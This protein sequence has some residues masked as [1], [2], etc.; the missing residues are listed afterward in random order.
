M[1]WVAGGGFALFLA[2]LI[3]VLV[4]EKRPVGPDLAITSTVNQWALDGGTFRVWQAITHFGESR[5]LTPLSI[6]LILIA[7]VTKRWRVAVFVAIASLYSM[8]SW[9][10]KV[11]VERPRPPIQHDYSLQQL[12]SFPSGHAG[13]AMAFASIAFC[14]VVMSLH[15]TAR[16]IAGVV[17]FAIAVLAGISRLALGVHYPTDVL[18]GFGLALA[19]VFSVALVVGAVA[20]RHVARTA[21]RQPLDV[22]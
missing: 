7:L 5:F 11:L 19:W 8:V 4:A 6:F 9:G 18:A 21:E 15:G 17:V 12:Q 22:A 16:V 3:A 10:V 1:W 20:D 13:G 14:V 2:M